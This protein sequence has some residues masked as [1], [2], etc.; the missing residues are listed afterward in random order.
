MTNTVQPDSQN[1][2]QASLV[3]ALTDLLDECRKAGFD[4]KS[5]YQWPERLDAADTALATARAAQAT[6]EPSSVDVG[7]I[8]GAI[9]EDVELA[10]HTMRDRIG[11]PTVIGE[12]RADAA[13]NVIDNL[14][15]HFRERRAHTPPRFS[16]RLAEYNLRMSLYKIGQKL[17]GE[18]LE[19][20][21]V[22]RLG[23]DIQSETGVC[24]SCGGN[25]QDG[26]GDGGVYTCGTCKGA[27][28]IVPSDQ[29]DPET[30][31]D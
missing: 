8:R 1:M 27:G 17:E 9:Y 19:E 30:R 21:D 16:M 20:E 12:D 24:R 3:T 6:P 4:A 29:F 5:G 10:C 26:D 7:A 14:L 2:I 22:V 23:S 28:I 31:H 11:M 25:G 15:A 13:H 18:E